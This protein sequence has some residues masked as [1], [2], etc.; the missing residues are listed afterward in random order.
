MNPSSPDNS[1][2]H[3][4]DDLAVAVGLLSLAL[5]VLGLLVAMLMPYDSQGAVGKAFAALF[6]QVAAIPA[7]LI[8]ILLSGYGRWRLGRF[9]RALVFGLIASI[10]AL[11]PLSLI[12]VLMV[13]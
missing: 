7:A 2:G 6:T 5:Q 4:V 13:A 11:I 9:D 8:G 12:Y 1:K 3:R 10:A